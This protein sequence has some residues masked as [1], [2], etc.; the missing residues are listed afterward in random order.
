VKPPALLFYAVE[1]TKRCRLW[2]VQSLAIRL[3]EHKRERKQAICIGEIKHRL[4]CNKENLSVWNVSVVGYI[5]EE[6]EY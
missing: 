2:V 4:K 6:K 3:E 1:L 5:N